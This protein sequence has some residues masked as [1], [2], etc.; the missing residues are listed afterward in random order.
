MSTITVENILQQIDQLPP[1]EQSRL[2][3]L[4]EER[5][6]ERA[7]Q[8]TKAPRDKRLPDQPAVDDTREREWIKQH[9]HEYAGQWVALDGDRLIAAS[10]NQAEVWAAVK[11]DGAKL[12]LVAR[13]RAFDEPLPIGI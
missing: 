7:P 5:R 8:P 10:P 4:L 12:P 9:R 6:V 13:I 1:F 2:A 3:Q 11:A